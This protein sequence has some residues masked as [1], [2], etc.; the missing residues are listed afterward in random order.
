MKRVVCM[1]TGS[2]LAAGMC[3][4]QKWE[5]GGAVGG[6]FYTS[7]S[8]TNTTAG[9]ASA[10]IGTGISAAAWLANTNTNRWGG[11]IRYDFQRGNLQLASG[12]ANASFG[13]Q[14]HT[15]HYDVHLHFADAEY[16]IRPFVAFGGGMKLFQ[17]TGAEVAAQPLSR[18]ALLTK[19]NDLRPVISVGAGVKAR[20]SD[21]WM[22]RAGVWN[23]MSPFPNKVIVPNTNSS[24][25]GWL[26]DF[27][28]MVGLSYLF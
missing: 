14:S 2:L 15:I 11:E 10:K 18:I 19:T 1:L 23:F 28:P 26:H 16:R 8:V 24:V 25:G 3:W 20:L 17:G 21:R 22:L 12:G 7:Q 4:G 13:A 6:G 5:F 9:S 27:T